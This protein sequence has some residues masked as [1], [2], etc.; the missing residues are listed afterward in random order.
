MLGTWLAQGSPHYPWQGANQHVTYISD[1][2]ASKFGYPLFI[3]G[4]AVMVVVFNLSFISE[5]WL[6]HKGRLAHNYSKTEK[7]LSVC[8]IIA[9]IIGGFGLIFLTIFNT[10]DYHPV[11]ISMLGVFI[12]GY[13]ISAIFIC[14]EYQRLGK[15]FREYRILRASFW[16]KLAFIFIEI[17]LAVAFGVT[18]YQGRYNISGYLEWIVSLVYIFYVWS[19]SP[20]HPPWPL[21]KITLSN[22]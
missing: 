20:S 1:V 7:M 6:R 8:A 17:A 18:Q 21:P 3:A 10:R 11:H 4:S 5:R 15:H 12:I 13:V 19:V 22:V 16:I 2:G 14:A 9:A